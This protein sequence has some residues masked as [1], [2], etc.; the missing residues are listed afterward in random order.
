MRF[1]FRPLAIF[2]T[3]D[4]K[5][6]FRTAQEYNAHLAKSKRLAK[7][8]IVNN[9]ILN[10]ITL[11]ENMLHDIIWIGTSFVDKA[12]AHQPP[13]NVQT[14][15]RTRIQKKITFPSAT[16]SIRYLTSSIQL[17]GYVSSCPLSK[18]VSNEWEILHDELQTWYNDIP[19]TRN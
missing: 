5:T 10:K 6:V 3:S 16:T 18:L 19:G 9:N 1:R 4:I 7:R 8:F 14:S 12:Q 15:E 13:E 11:N 17:T 2:F